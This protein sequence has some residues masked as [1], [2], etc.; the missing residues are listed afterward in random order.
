MTRSVHVLILLPLALVFFMSACAT[1]QY[2][3]VQELSVAEEVQYTCREIYIEFDKLEQ[4]ERQIEK[5]GQF[6]TKTMLS[7]FGR[8]WDWKQHGEEGCQRICVT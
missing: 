8:L 3:R 5:T 2:G 4:F 6:N 7:I 1:K